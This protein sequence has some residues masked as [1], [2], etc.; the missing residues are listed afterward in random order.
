M[1]DLTNKKQRRTCSL[2]YGDRKFM[3]GPLEDLKCPKRHQHQIQYSDT[4]WQ[5]GGLA[6]SHWCYWMD[7]PLTWSSNKL[8]KSFFVFWGFFCTFL[9][10]VNNMICIFWKL[11]NLLA[12]FAVDF[13]WPHWVFLTTSAYIFQPLR[14]LLVQRIWVREEYEGS[15]TSE[16]KTSACQWAIQHAGKPRRIVC[17]ASVW[18]SLV[19]VN[20][21]CH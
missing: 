21:L 7:M 14:L 15:E 16:S 4:N 8:Q 19:P 13:R 1:L 10:T 20:S 12:A 6:A 2:F 5:N 9:C 18:S 17:A 11:G 3:K